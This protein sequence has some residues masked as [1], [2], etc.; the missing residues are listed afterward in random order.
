MRYEQRFR[1]ALLGAFLTGALFLV[2][3]KVG[4][5]AEPLYRLKLPTVIS[6]ELNLPSLVAYANGYFTEERIEVTD[7]VLASGGTLRVAVI[8]KEYD[9]GLFAFVHVPLARIAGSPWKA[10]LSTHDLEIFSLV[11]RSEL[12]DKVKSVA[13]LKGR[14]VGFSTPGAGS[15]YMGSLFLKKAGLD[16]EK[17]LQYISLGGDPGVIYAALKTGKVDA[18]PSWE[19]TTTRI[20]EEGVAYPLVKIWEPE[21]HKKWVGETALSLVL[22]TREDVIKEKPDL[23]RRMVNAH[24]KGLSFV[25]GRGASEIAEVVLRNPKTAEQFKGLSQPLVVKILDRI[26]GGFGSGCLSRSGFEVEMKLAVEHKLVKRPI[27]F[28]EFADTSFA[29]ACP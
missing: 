28:A 22:V 10:V 8:A 25:R 13:D 6:Y 29:G 5:Q 11:V 14:K 9:L 3:G 19:P 15:W 20:I 1:Q 12:K 21:E 4:S 18:F 23:V 7:F 26:K 2:P 16:P 27:T 24:K 17:D